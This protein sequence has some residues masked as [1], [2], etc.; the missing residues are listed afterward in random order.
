MT[1]IGILG[2][3]QLGRMLALA[4]YPLGLRFRFLDPAAE[5]PAEQLAERMIGAYEDLEVLQQFADGID[6]VTYEFENVPWHTA[7]FLQQRLPVFP[8]AAALEAA[9][10]RVAEKQFFKRLDIPTPDFRAVENRADL[11]AAVENLGLPAIL[12]TRRFGYDG[13]GQYLLH[14]PAEVLPAWEALGG[15]PLILESLVPFVRE[16]SLLALRSRTGETAFYP[17]V[18]NHHRDGM[19]RLSLAPAPRLRSKVQSEAEDYGRRVLEAVEYVGLLAIEFFEVTPPKSDGPRLLAN[20]MA[21]RVHNSGHW[22]IE[23][24]QT[25][26]FENHLRAILGLPLG[27]T[28]MRGSAAMVNLIGTAPDPASVLRHQGVHLHLYGKAP[29][30]KRKL[31]HIT[32]CVEDDATRQTRLR[33]LAGQVEDLRLLVESGAV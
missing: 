28:G 15:V 17:L 21:P 19:L 4:G 5:A 1:T 12:K 27:S 2:A 22:T 11:Q 30:P 24:S 20:E 7:S 25:S 33:E 32:V 26:Q 18:E 13:K 6:L 14:E 10:D 23:G 31:G 16:V 9:Q 8:P 3:G 29:R